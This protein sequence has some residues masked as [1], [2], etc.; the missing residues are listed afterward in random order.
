MHHL[1][2]LSKVIME[3]I[4]AYYSPY[5]N[6]YCSKVTD[7]APCIYPHDVAGPAEIEPARLAG[8]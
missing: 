3:N 7:E 8:R 2:I 5:D 6:T 1:I 4:S